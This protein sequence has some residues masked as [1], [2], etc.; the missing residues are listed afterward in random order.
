M[1]KTLLIAAAALV[2]CGSEQITN[3]GLD[4]DFAYGSTDLESYEFP[5]SGDFSDMTIRWV[6]TNRSDQT[7]W[8]HE[9]GAPDPWLQQLV[10]GEWFVRGGPRADCFGAHQVRAGEE[11]FGELAVSRSDL[12]SSF[13]APS[14]PIAGVYR[15]IW[16]AHYEYDPPAGD[17]PVALRI[18]NQF[19]IRD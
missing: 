16:N 15:L 14:G 13:P 7:V 11:L 2:G 9:C 3:Q 19:V 18:S 1:R 5:D 4:P 6:F 17:L 12:Y 8:V 10:D